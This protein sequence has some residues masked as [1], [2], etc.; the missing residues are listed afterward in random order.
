MTAEIVGDF[1]AAGGMSDHDRVFEIEGIEQLRQIVGVGVHLIA[2]PGLAGAAVASAVVRDDAIA[3]LAE[4]QHLAVPIV[5]GERP[6]VAEYDGLSCAPVLIENCGS[7]FGSD[8]W[9]GML[10]FSIRVVSKL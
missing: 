5:R 6:A 3:A 4:E 9:H 7:V 1:A 2:V 10:S 8:C